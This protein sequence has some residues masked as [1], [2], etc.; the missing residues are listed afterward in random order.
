MPKKKNGNKNLP[1]VAERFA[2]LK[3]DTEQVKQVMNANLGAGGIT[4]FSLDRVRIP[5][6]GGTMWEMPT[7]EG[8]M[9]APEF[10][11]VIVYWQDIRVYFK[12]EYTGEKMPPDCASEDCITG[13]GEPGGACEV[14]PLAKF[15]SNTRGTGKG[16]ACKQCRRLFVCQTDTLL[17]LLVTLPPTRLHACAKHFR[18]LAAPA[19][20]FYGVLTRFSLEKEKNA[21]GIVYSRVSMNVAERF[22]P[23]LQ[24]QW[25]RIHQMFAPLLRRIP[26]EAADYYA[27]GKD[28]E[29]AA[30]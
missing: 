24:E 28:D 4:P 27:E 12:G 1:A 9:S 8:T 6:G 23:K 26:T 7:L 21:T 18:R 3:Q 30:E 14:C 17:P 11:G 16:Q 13:F 22:D 29:E 20:P 25:L 19:I 2:I 5:A 15:G 10:T